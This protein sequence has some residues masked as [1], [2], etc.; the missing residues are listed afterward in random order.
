MQKLKA[1]DENFESM[2]ELIN[3]TSTYHDAATVITAL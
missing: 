2:D 3:G 1:V